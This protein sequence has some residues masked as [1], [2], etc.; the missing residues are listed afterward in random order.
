MAKEVIIAL[1]F[2]GLQV[3]ELDVWD[4]PLSAVLTPAVLADPRYPHDL[5]ADSAE[6]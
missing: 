4:P 6:A 2:P 3:H 1:D 5:R